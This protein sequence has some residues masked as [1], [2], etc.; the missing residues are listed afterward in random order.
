MVYF[1]R[2]DGL[3]PYLSSCNV[4]CPPFFNPA[5]FVIKNITECTPSELKVIMY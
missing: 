1:G 5:E 3:V 4:P 2:A